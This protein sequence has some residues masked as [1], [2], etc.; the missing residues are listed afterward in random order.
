[1]S[2]TFA[3]P[4]ES[5][6]STQDARAK[7][8]RETSSQASDIT[9][10][11]AATNNDSVSSAGV[12]KRGDVLNSRKKRKDE[13]GTTLA[14]NS[15]AH[16]KKAKK[17]SARLRIPGGTSD[18]PLTLSDSEES[19]VESDG[20][21]GASAVKASARTAAQLAGV[22]AS[23]GRR[24]RFAQRFT[25]LTPEE[26]LGKFCFISSSPRVPCG[27]PCFISSA[28]QRMALPG[29]QAFLRPGD[30]EGPERGHGSQVHL[31]EVRTP[32]L[33]FYSYTR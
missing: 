26:T 19:A 27:L 2:Q 23:N 1:M 33:C 6:K 28:L 17:G 20:D 10:G 5:L 8:R 16:G 7:R 3:M 13:A 24:A 18:T 32:D 30:C 25:G 4:S 21:E 12:K 29:L 31:Q 9:Q 11:A 14:S 22:Q 15:A